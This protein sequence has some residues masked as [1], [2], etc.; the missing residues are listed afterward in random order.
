MSANKPTAPPQRLL[1]ICLKGHDHFT[2]DLTRALAPEVAV[3]R[4]V[5]TEANDFV[6]PIQR[7]ST[8]WVEWGDQLAVWLTRQGAALL[9]GKRLILR[10]HSYEI[11]DGFCDNID[12]TKVDDLVLVAPHMRDI[13]FARLPHV[14]QQVGRVHVIPNGVDLDRFAFAPRQAGPNIAM[15]G[16]VNYKKD[17]MVMLHAFRE[18]CRAEPGLH[19]HVAGKFEN[20]R[21]ELAFQH[22]AA[23]NGLKERIH[24]HGWVDD[25]AAWLA[26]KHYIMVS[27]VMEGHPVAPLEAMA[28]GI[29]PLIHSFL[30]AEALFPREL[31]W[32][33][34][35]E[36]LE[37]VRGPYDSQAYRDFVAAHYSLARQAQAFKDM[38]R[39]GR[40]TPTTKTRRG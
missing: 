12:F 23:V 4:V 27:S 3:E 22:F 2:G 34:F 11:L 38:L 9:Q 29:R 35:G 33:D 20:I 37:M 31:V 10:M 21:Y 25:V 40:S 7:H 16:N 30:G 39:G 24:L 19:L 13:L 8:I 26:D 17:P 15:V 36:L 14:R 5:S 18:L 28:R 6:A 1:L 32:R